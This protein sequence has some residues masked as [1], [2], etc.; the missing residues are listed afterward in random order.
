MAKT[1]DKTRS[2]SS[3]IN[4]I[5]NKTGTPST[6]V[7]KATRSRIRKMRERNA[8]QLYKEWP[9]LRKHERNAPYPPMP[10]SFA[11]KIIAGRVAAMSRNATDELS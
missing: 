10:T 3:V 1:A 11:D 5:A 9:Q 6:D 4:E 2:L 7:G 8:T